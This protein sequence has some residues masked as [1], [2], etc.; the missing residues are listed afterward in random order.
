MC[1]GL[2]NFDQVFIRYRAGDRGAMRAGET[3]CTCGRSSLSLAS[4]EGRADDVL[5]TTD[6]RRVGRLDPVFKGGMHLLE[7]QVIQVASDEIHVKIVPAPGYSED[8]ADSIASRI[9]DRMGPMKVKVIVVDG[10]PR[11]A[12]GKFRAVINQVGK[13]PAQEQDPVA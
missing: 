13:R 7:A 6:G 2:L 5:V 10:I 9:R 4:I 8:E 3:P 11:S 12:N 1:T